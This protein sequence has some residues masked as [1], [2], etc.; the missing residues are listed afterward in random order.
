MD[1]MPA[2]DKRKNAVLLPHCPCYASLAMLKRILL[3]AS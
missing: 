3:L 1:P 2:H